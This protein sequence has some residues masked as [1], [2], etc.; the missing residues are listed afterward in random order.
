M[1]LDDPRIVKLIWDKSEIG[2]AVL[3]SD[4]TFLALNQRF[5]AIVEYSQAELVGKKF[6]E[7]THPKD[8]GPDVSM[9]RLL[10][11]G[12]IDHYRMVKTYI[13]K[14]GLPVLVELVVWP[15]QKED[16]SF[17][18][19]LSQIIPKT[20]VTTSN[21]KSTLEIDASTV[22]A[23]LL[24]DNKALVAKAMGVIVAILTAVVTILTK[25]AEKI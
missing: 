22:L 8:T 20:E 17:E 25:L 12:S 1:P 23:K 2:W 9:A 3:A 14:S 6:Q 24:T 15:I 18:Y 19:F 21:D 13:K 7:I 16:G 11:Q 5:G 10:Q 4:G